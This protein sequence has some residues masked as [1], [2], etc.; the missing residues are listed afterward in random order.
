MDADRETLDLIAASLQYPG[1]A[2]A[3]S[4]RRAAERT[5]G[6]H[7]AM[8][9]ALWDLAVA[10]E[11]SPPGEAEERYTALFDL[12]PVCTLHVGYHLFGESYPRGALL[13]GLRTELRRVG[14]DDTADLPDFLPTLLRLLGRVEAP[15]D[16]E[17]LLGSALLPGL[18][19]MVHE[20]GDS[21]SPWSDVL[22]AL[23]EV[24]TPAMLGEAGPIASAP[25]ASAHA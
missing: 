25:E 13:V 2:T 22:R 4:A 8:A 20:L 16:R 21:R 3:A 7:I 23:P 12:S 6:D 24:L 18:A 1:P 17:V 14:L 15:E 9:H 19:R 5:A 10:L 11:T